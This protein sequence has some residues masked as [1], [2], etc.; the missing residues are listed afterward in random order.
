MSKTVAIVGASGSGKSTIS[1][2]IQRLYIPEGGKVLLDGLDISQVDPTW[3]RQQIGIVMQENF[4]FNG[5]VRENIAIAAPSARMDEVIAAA[6]TAGAHDFIA[7][8]AEG[9]DTNVGERGASLSGGQ[10]QRIAIARALMTNPIQNH[11]CS[12]SKKCV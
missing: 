4:L 8:L 11:R 1:K 5:S 9:Y 6:R 10:K 7:E 2:L 12:V 3:V